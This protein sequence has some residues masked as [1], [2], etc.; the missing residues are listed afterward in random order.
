MTAIDQHILQLLDTLS[1]DGKETA[2]KML[3][4]SKKKKKSNTAIKNKLKRSLFSSHH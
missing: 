2:R 1:E 4:K 3:G